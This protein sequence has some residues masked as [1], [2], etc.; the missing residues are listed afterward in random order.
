MLGFFGENM[1]QETKMKILKK[2]NS[3][4]SKKMILWEFKITDKELKGIAREFK[5]PVRS[6]DE[7]T[8]A[9]K[10]HKKRT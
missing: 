5:I 10:L 2:I 3:G 7:I 4:Q 6:V 9:N 1:N 8:Y